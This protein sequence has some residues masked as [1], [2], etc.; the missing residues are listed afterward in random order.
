MTKTFFTDDHEYVR[1]EGDVG[2]VGVSDY[3]Q[4]A[5]GD[6]VYVE[7]PKIGAKVRQGDQ[8]GVIESVKSASE[9]FS[10]VTGDVVE[11]NAALT[12]EP[13]LVNQSPFGRGWFY[14]VKLDNKSELTTLKDET[15]Y[16]SYIQ[17]L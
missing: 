13:A 10:P 2:T 5:L 14:K 12:G 3:A 6:V 15:S 9:I 1:V 8:A 7:L 17:G 4:R 16:D 11:V